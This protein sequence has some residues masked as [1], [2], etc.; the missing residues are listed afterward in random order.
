MALHET[1]R[2]FLR[3]FKEI[4]TAENKDE[5]PKGVYRSSRY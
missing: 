3:A 4:A 2:S 1:K 5:T